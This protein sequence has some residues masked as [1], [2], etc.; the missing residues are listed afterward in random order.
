MELCVPS[1]RASNK[2][3]VHVKLLDLRLQP[4]ATQANCV[5]SADAILAYQQAL[6]EAKLCACLG[7][8]GYQLRQPDIFIYH[9]KQSKRESR[10]VLRIV[11]NGWSCFIGHSFQV[12]AFRDISPQAPMHILI[13]PKSND[14]LTGLSKNSKFLQFV[15]KMSRCELIID[16]NQV[17]PASENWAT[18]YQ[19]QYNGGASWADEFAHDE[20]SRDL[21]EGF[22]WT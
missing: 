10:R 20:A 2:C 12:L 22:P 9:S 11:K 4:G 6:V 5:Q 3:N 18:E 21:V 15:S 17:K 8:H 19:Q 16:D 7:K 1:H 14:G 13:I